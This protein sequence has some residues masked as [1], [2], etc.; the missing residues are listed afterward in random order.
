MEL[1]TNEHIFV[2][3]PRNDVEF[4]MSPEARGCVLRRRL[5][6][7]CIIELQ[8]ILCN[9]NGFYKVR[10]PNLKSNKCKERQH[11]TH[12]IALTVKSYI[13]EPPV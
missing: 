8:G 3:S 2:P 4:V 13:S 9:E 11:L 6:F 10:F 7:V 12:R 5:N 1:D